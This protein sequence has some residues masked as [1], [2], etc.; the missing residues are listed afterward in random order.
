LRFCRNVL[1]YCKAPLAELLC[2][3]RHRSSV[4]MMM[5]MIGA[6]LLEQSATEVF[7]GGLSEGSIHG[8]YDKLDV[9]DQLTD[10]RLMTSFLEN[11][12]NVVRQENANFRRDM[13]TSALRNYAS[14]TADDVG[15]VV[16]T[17]TSALRN[18]SSLT[19]DDV[20]RVV[21]VMGKLRNGSNARQS[22]A[23]NEAGRLPRGSQPPNLISLSFLSPLPREDYVIRPCV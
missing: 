8:E 1:S 4:M 9:E 19:A 10:L 13:M 17:L 5:I 7:G 20:G 21:D 11:E 14:L 12:L 6:C 18:H 3:R 16:D 23:N 15:R 2:K 22:L